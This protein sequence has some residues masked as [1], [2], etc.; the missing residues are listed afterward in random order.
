MMSKGTNLKRQE[1]PNTPMA[2]GK[3]KGSKSKETEERIEH[4]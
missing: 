1:K 4:N 3:K 2:K